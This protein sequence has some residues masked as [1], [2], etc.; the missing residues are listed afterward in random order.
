MRSFSKKQGI[1]AAVVS[2]LLLLGLFAW[3]AFSTPIATVR[4]SV[5]TAA[6]ARTPAWTPIGPLVFSEVNEGDIRLGTVSIAA[7]TGFEFNTATPVNVRLTGGGNNKQNLNEVATGTNIAATGANLTVTENLISFAVNV[8]SNGNGTSSLAWEGVQVRPKQGTPLYTSNIIITVPPGSTYP[9]GSRNLGT[10]QMVVGA[11]D[12][13]VTVLP[14]QSFSAGSGV[15]GTTPPV[16]AGTS[17]I[18]TQLVATDQ[19]FNVIPSFTGGKTI[20][21][22]S[23]VP[24]CTNNLFTTAVTFAAG[25]SS[26]TLATTLYGAGTPTITARD[27]ATNVSGPA[28]SAKT[29]TALAASKMLITLP[30]QALGTC[31]NFTGTPNNQAPGVPFPIDLTATDAYFN[32]ATS[33]AGGKTISYT[34]G[35]T[36][37]TYPSNPITFSAGTASGLVSILTPQPAVQLSASQAGVTGILSSTFTVVTNTGAL[38][39]FE[40]GTANASGPI[41]TKVAGLA[42]TLEL[43]ALTTSNQVNTSAIGTVKVEVVDASNPAD[44]CAGRPRIFLHSDHTFA[45]G[46]QGRLT[47]APLT[48]STTWKDAR[49]RLSYPAA[50]PVTISCSRDNFAIRPAR[51]DNTTVSHVTSAGATESLIGSPALGAVIHRAGQPFSIGATAVNQAGGSMLYNGSPVVL[52]TDCGASTLCPNSPGTVTPGTWS[53]SGA[54]ATSS[55]TYSEVGAVTMQL[56]DRTFAD[57]DSA[58]SS[59]LERYFQGTATTVNRFVPDHFAV[60]NAFITN[61]SNGVNGTTCTSDFTYMN[62][63]LKAS[64]TLTAHN[65]QFGTTAN[66]TGDLARLNP[67][68]AHFLNF[69]AVNT[70]GTVVKPF[71]ARITAI[72]RG[73]PGR[74]TT[75][76]PGHGLTTGSTVYLSGIG[77]MTQ[78]N[79]LSPTVIV[80]NATTFDINQDTSGFTAFSAGGSAS[81]VAFQANPVA[82]SAGVLVNNATFTL[83]RLAGA[84]GPYN[85]TA[86]GVLPIDPDGIT[87]EPSALTVNADGDSPAT[88]DRVLL[89]TSQFRFG[90]LALRPSYGSQLLDL[91]IPLELQQYNGNGFVINP[92][93]SCGR[94]LGAN[95]SLDGHAGGVTLDNLPQTNLPGLVAFATGGGTILLQRPNPA[96]TAKGSAL[97]TIDLGP[98]GANLPFLLGNWGGVN[99]TA[100]PSVRVTFGNYRSTPVIYAREI[101]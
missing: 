83:T 62:E 80:I 3:A 14:G 87:V 95:M 92:D 82:W 10:L 37:T 18:N 90:R 22:T 25:Y 63:T 42:F 57:V 72:S 61:R 31:G 97:L 9:Q 94:L 46:N 52:A 84:D 99:Y 91:R 36:G 6:T 64:F 70:A 79:G 71:V 23:S 48:V 17:F 19:F 43:V 34:G 89:G 8:L 101:F 1:T 21:Y 73:N 13:I 66:Y 49:F 98:A 78:L 81:R 32:V 44:S 69:G 24:T 59:V 5:D 60:S 33:Y 85:N 26:N 29:V 76:L 12:K 50:A 51:F 68:I 58:D 2:L 86:I 100:N 55:A 93:D 96:P 67:A 35:P 28:S 75:A 88:M 54:I 38:D 4:I 11:L 41:K 77:G 45:P 16:N 39:V 56:E 53:G 47:M 65:A 74:V 40:T 20:A 7:P 27:T 15:S 30:G